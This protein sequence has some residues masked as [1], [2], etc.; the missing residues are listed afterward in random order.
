MSRPMSESALSV[1]PADPHWHLLDAY[2][3]QGDG[4]PTLDVTTPCRTT[5]TSLDR[6][7]CD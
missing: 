3:E 1:I 6:P 7:T 2:D 4:L 5:A